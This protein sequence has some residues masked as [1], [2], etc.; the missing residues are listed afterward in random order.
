[1]C[2]KD[3]TGNSG[4]AKHLCDTFPIKHALTRGDALSQL[5]F[6]LNLEYNLRCPEQ[7]ARRNHNIRVD[8]K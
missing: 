3:P 5:L 2:L 7:N 1:M 4:E 6:A 8:N